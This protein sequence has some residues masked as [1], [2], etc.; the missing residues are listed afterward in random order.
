[1]GGEL[2]FAAGAVGGEGE[3]LVGGEESDPGAFEAVL[4]VGGDVGAA[5]DAVDGLADDEVEPAVGEFGL[6]EKFL[7]AAVPLDG[8]GELFVRGARASDGE[9]F[10]AGLDVVEVR[11]DQRVLGQ[12]ELGGPELTRQ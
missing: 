3:G 1:M 6:G 11:H 9:V 10:A 12:H 4:D 5:G 2:G 7:D 8:D